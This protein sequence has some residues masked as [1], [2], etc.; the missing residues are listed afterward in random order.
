MKNKNFVN[1][2]KGK[3]V[4]KVFDK[5]KAEVNNDVDKKVEVQSKKQVY[6]KKKSRE[7]EQEDFWGEEFEKEG[8][9]YLLGV[10]YKN[11]F[12]EIDYTYEILL[13]L[14]KY[15][16]SEIKDLAQGSQDVVMQM[17][18]EYLSKIKKYDEK[19]I[20]D[21]IEIIVKYNLLETDY[22]LY[23]NF[24]YEVKQEYKKELFESLPYEVR[25][26]IYFQEGFR[27]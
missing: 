4:K 1:L 13:R 24:L 16:H 8:K 17:I 6:G 18:R 14:H 5:A 3:S 9:L 27:S 19:M 22:V 20:E 12:D 25:N 21:M 7:S 26:N 15:Y 11:L 10:R 2:L 23:S